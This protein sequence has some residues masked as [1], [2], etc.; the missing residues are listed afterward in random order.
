[1]RSQSHTVQLEDKVDLPLLHASF[2]REALPRLQT[3]VRIIAVAVGGSFL[4]DGMDEYSDLDLVVALEP[5]AARQVMQERQQ[6]AATLGHLLVAFTGEHV[7]EP[8]LLICLY[9]PPLLHVDLK[10]VSLPDAATRVEDPVIL[11]EREGRLTTVLQTTEAV[12]PTP[13]LQWLED[14]FWVWVHYCATKLGR[15][16]LF[17]ALDFLAFLRFQVLGPLALL[18]Q[19]K[20]PSGV[21][22]VET[23]AHRYLPDL[24]RTTASYDR[25]ACVQALQASA[26]FYQQLRQKL[27]SEALTVRTEAEKAALSY[28]NDIEQRIRGAEKNSDK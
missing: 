1:M 4:T 24:L 5:S 3:D 17:E 12:Y 27:A 9:G 25:L 8:R 15:G 10:F 19:G 26:T 14:R 6:I 28:L 16:E 2:L 20:R 21:R 7:G 18:E 13:D 11:W 22:K 23:L